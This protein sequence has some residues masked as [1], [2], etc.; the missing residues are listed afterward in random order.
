MMKAANSAP[1][2]GAKKSKPEMDSVEPPVRVLVLAAFLEEALR[3]RQRD[4]RVVAVEVELIDG[5]D[6]EQL[7]IL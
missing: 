3:L 4:P 5:V 6:V 7:R 2:D 1:T